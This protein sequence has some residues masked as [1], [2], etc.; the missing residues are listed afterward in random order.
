MKPHQTHSGFETLLGLYFT[1][2]PFT[3]YL[4]RLVPF[5]YNKQNKNSANCNKKRPRHS[6]KPFP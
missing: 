1:F 4:P 3:F 6:A 5:I 2:L